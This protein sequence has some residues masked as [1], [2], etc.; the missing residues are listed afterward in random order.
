MANVENAGAV[1]YLPSASRQSKGGI[2]HPE[3]APDFAVEIE[4]CVLMIE[5]KSQAE[6]TD[7]KM[8]AKADAAVKRCENASDYLMKNGGKPWKYLLIPHDK[9][10]ENYQL[11][12]YAK[13]FEKI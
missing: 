10:K 12:D 13:K 3:Y 2:D 4:S 11:K 1:F 7:T 9:I 5:T 6:M 8:Q